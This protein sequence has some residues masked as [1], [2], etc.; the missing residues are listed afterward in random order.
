[1]EGHWVRKLKSPSRSQ[2][3][4]LFLLRAEVAL[5]HSVGYD[6]RIFSGD[7]LEHLSNNFY[8]AASDGQKRA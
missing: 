7:F 8:D 4:F 2:V 5:S 6:S 1:L 3:S